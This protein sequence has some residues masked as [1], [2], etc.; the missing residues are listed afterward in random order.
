MRQVFK[1]YPWTHAPAPEAI[2][3][4]FHENGRYCRLRKGTAIFNGGA[5]GEIALVLSGIGA[6]SFPDHRANNHIFTLIF[7]KSL[8]GDVDG[9]TGE[10]VNVV[11]SAFRMMEVRLLRRKV[12][13]KFLS[14][15]P[16]AAHEH[17]LGVISDHE[18]DME[19]LLA[20]FTLPL[21]K[22]IA[23]LF[24]SLVWRTGSELI[25]GIYRLP[26]ALK[27]TEIGQIVSASRQSVSSILCGWEA[28]N[29]LSRTRGGTLIS[30]RLINDSFDWTREVRKPF[31]LPGC[32]DY[33]FGRLPGVREI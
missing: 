8:M 28:G 15:H 32:K 13:A 33:S 14:E 31:N 11:D 27:A 22:R 16:V 2:Q 4:F 21:A 24:E 9:L 5:A 26:L 20:N 23:A 6:F 10:T 17:T 7:P 18:S 30:S 1:S 29:L 3:R 12:F 25:E 19:G